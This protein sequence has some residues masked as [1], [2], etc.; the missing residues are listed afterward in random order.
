[1]IKNLT[2]LLGNQRVMVSSVGL[3]FSVLILS[4]LIMGSI[5]ASYTDTVRGSSESIEGQVSDYVS[6]DLP[7]TSHDKYPDIERPEASAK[8]RAS[9]LDSNTNKSE[10]VADV[11]TEETFNGKIVKSVAI[12]VHV[13]KVKTDEIAVLAGESIQLSA[14]AFD[15]HG[16]EIEDVLLGWQVSSALYGVIDRTGLFTAGPKSGRFPSA[17]RV[18]VAPEENN[19]MRKEA[20]IDLNIAPSALDTVV[21]F[22]DAP[23]LF[24]G[25]SLKFSVQ[26]KDTFGNPVPLAVSEWNAEGGEIQ[27]DGTFRAGRDPGEYKIFASVMPLADPGKMTQIDTG[28]TLEHG[29]CLAEDLGSRWDFQIS[30]YHSLSPSKRSLISV[31]EVDGNFHLTEKH[32]EHL[33]TT[34]PSVSLSGSTTIVVPTRSSLQFLIGANGGYWLLVDGVAV[35]TSLASGGYS[36]QTIYLDLDPGEHD[37]EIGYYKRNKTVDLRFH[38]TDD[39]VNLRSVSQCTGTYSPVLDNAH[40][41]YTEDH[42]DS[43][44]IS[45]RFGVEPNRVISIDSDR[46]MWLIMSSVSDQIAYVDELELVTGSSTETD[47]SDVV[48]SDVPDQGLSG[49]SIQEDPADYEDTAP[50]TLGYFSFAPISITTSV[51]GATVNVTL[52]LTDSG[53]GVCWYSCSD[54]SSMTQARFQHVASGQIR[55]A[56]FN[57]ASGTVHDGTFEAELVFP[58]GSAKGTW[59]V[60]DLLLADDLGNR[61]YYPT[62]ELAAIGFPTELLNGN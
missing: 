11:T 52:R 61:R 41:L 28:M 8:T 45:N 10:G 46:G 21:I 49:N 9:A 60:T 55:D 4:I 30:D 32:F 43:D 16:F 15:R 42:V 53:S 14:S 19:A 20:L 33:D 7:P 57:L 36:E 56:I 5:P 59:K 23:R 39:V 47:H 35:A 34:E 44:G 25:E 37:L 1:M 38:A 12:S 18:Y 40:F 3:M 31:L 24:T 29:S 58:R 6:Y 51:T 2:N 48:S 50:P 26:G 62:S 17:I 13:L 54:Q 22:P 27:T